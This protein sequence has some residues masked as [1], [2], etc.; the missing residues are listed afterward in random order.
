[1]PI[2]RFGKVFSLDTLDK[3]D[4]DLLEPSKL[5]VMP[6]IH[7]LQKA[8]TSEHC[9]ITVADAKTKLDARTATP[10]AGLIPDPPIML[11]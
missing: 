1:M 9:H 5:P 10:T 11:S 8:L 7:K 4:S 2:I 6:S 3:V